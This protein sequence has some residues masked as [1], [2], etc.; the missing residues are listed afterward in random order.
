MP[1]LI[2][3]QKVFWGLTIV[4][5]GLP[6]IND[7]TT[8]SASQWNSQWNDNELQ[9]VKKYSVKTWTDYKMNKMFI[10]D[11]PDKL[12]FHHPKTG[13]LLQIKLVDL[14]PFNNIT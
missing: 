10:T 2:D 13:A 8:E 5:T 12:M 3:K 6:E 7:S 4:I 1:P 9:H 11:L 14:L